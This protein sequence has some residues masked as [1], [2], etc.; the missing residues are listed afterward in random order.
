MLKEAPSDSLPAFLNLLKEPEKNLDFS[1]DFLQLTTAGENEKW[2][3]L[4]AYYKS[5]VNQL[6]MYKWGRTIERFNLSLGQF[7]PEEKE[8]ISE[9]LNLTASKFNRS[10]SSMDKLNDDLLEYFE[11]KGTG[12]LSI[13]AQLLNHHE[14][15]RYKLGDLD[16]GFPKIREKFPSGWNNKKG[17]ID[18]PSN[19]FFWG[20]IEEGKVDKWAFIGDFVVGGVKSFEIEG[21]R[22][23]MFVGLKILHPKNGIL[24][25]AKQLKKLLK[26]TV[27]SKVTWTVFQIYFWKTEAILIYH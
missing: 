17:A 5:Y 7:T 16:F 24:E 26:H 12:G 23:D 3:G 10:A 27:S 22:I 2:M 18:W 1:E 11:S 13:V 6:V 14:I 21:E 15:W 25:P 9:L 8:K 4:A 19:G 20:K